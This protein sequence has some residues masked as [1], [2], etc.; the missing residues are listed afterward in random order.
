LRVLGL[1]AALRLGV[2]LVAASSPQRF[3]SLDDRDYIGLATHLHAGY[4]ASAGDW[5]DAGLRRPP[6]YPLLIRGVYDVFG[7]HYGPVIA[8]QIVIAVATVGL[9][10]WL[11]PNRY[12]RD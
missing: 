3:W 9:V 12:F 11:L 6:A 5:F 7:R 8:A 2:F 10:Y 4:L 1:A